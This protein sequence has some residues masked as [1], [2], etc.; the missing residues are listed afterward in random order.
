M[1]DIDLIS[2]YA[3]N[4]MTLIAFLAIKIITFVQNVSVDILLSIAIANLVHI[5]ALNVMNKGKETVIKEA[6]IMAMQGSIIVA[7]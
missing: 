5:I 3:K 7:V 6:A 2:I 1:K 4:V